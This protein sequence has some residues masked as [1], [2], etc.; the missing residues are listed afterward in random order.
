[1]HKHIHEI[2]KIFVYIIQKICYII[3]GLRKNLVTC[4]RRYKASPNKNTTAR[5]S[6]K[7]FIILIN[8]FSDVKAKI[9]RG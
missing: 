1:M 8:P 9:E 3:V 6:E 7:A 5:H 4:A 2:N